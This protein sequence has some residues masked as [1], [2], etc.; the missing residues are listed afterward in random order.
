M[1]DNR[2][3]RIGRIPYANLFP[4]FYA[5]ERVGDCAAY[6]FV[7]GV[8]SRVNRMLRDGTVDISPSS[9]IE[10]LR[11]PSRY[12]IIEGNSI[13]SRG[14]VGSVFLFSERP[15]EA[16]G[17]ADIAVTS[18]SE[19]SVALLTVILKKFYNLDCTLT[20]AD[21]PERS[22]TT[23]FLLIGD[24]ALKYVDNVSSG[25]LTYDLGEIWYDRT[26][27]PFVFALWIM[28]PE[29]KGE[30]KLLDRFL[31]DLHEA[32]EYALQH[33]PEIAKPAPLRNFMSE[34]EILDYWNKL[35]YELTE[36][37]KK[38]LELFGRYVKELVQD[39]T[40]EDT[41]KPKK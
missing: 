40:T 18:Q 30:K 28:R 5:L 15:I 21:A 3:L 38:G 17:G 36:D 20:V 12:E 39:K 4:I 22:G 34:E 2:K 33:L 6:E 1:N 37:H 24:D 41:E 29:I 11:N 19:T 25:M 14:P 10:Y 9:S 31:R 8:P 23:A 7:E 26:G 35:D 27:L 13:S 16:L 32:K